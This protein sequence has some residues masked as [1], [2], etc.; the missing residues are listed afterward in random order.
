M[1]LV[2]RMALVLLAFILSF[3]LASSVCFSQQD[4]DSGK[5]PPAGGPGP[6]QGGGG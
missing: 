6:T 2:K 3:V 1:L 4:T 5:P